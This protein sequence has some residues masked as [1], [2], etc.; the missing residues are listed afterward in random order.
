[1]R[2]S[3]NL[4]FLR[5]QPVILVE[6]ERLA[7]QH[8]KAEQMTKSMTKGHLMWVGLLQA[9]KDRRISTE[10]ALL[11]FYITGIDALARILAS[12]TDVECG[13][14]APRWWYDMDVLAWVLCSGDRS[15]NRRYFSAHPLARV[16]E[17][18]VW[19]KHV[20]D[21][22]TLDPDVAMAAALVAMLS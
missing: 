12:L 15:K 4:E 14:T 16:F 11:L 10:V 19:L 22:S 21:L 20:P 7:R 13:A 18:Y 5:N 9:D 2:H 6:A 8:Y 3:D 1:M 17:P